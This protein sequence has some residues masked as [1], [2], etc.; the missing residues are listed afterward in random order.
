MSEYNIDCA[1]ARL[2]EGEKC[3][4][5]G[6]VQLACMVSKKRKKEE[7]EGRKE[8]KEKLIHWQCLELTVPLLLLFLWLSIESIGLLSITHFIFL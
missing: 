7:K 3:D 1:I 2:T 6:H 5:C 8:L 4:I